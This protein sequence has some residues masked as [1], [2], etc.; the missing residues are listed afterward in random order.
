[1]MSGRF[2]AYF[3]LG[4]SAS[5]TKESR[6]LAVSKVSPLRRR[7]CPV[8]E[9]SREKFLRALGL[10]PSCSHCMSLVDERCH[11]CGGATVAEFHD[12]GRIRWFCFSCRWVGWSAF[13]V[14]PQ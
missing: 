11:K 5:G 3:L 9:V 8:V 6:S 13:S 10:S 2:L 14:E 4:I 7:V 12:D 1:M